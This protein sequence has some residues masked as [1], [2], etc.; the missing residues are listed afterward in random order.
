MKAKNESVRADQLVGSTVE[1]VAWVVHEI[2]T[3]GAV[4]VSKPTGLDSKVSLTGACVCG[5][6][7]RSCVCVCVCTCVCA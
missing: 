7:G 4:E 6:G 1:I 5:G 3:G 2:H